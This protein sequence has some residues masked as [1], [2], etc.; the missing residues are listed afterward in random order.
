MS[1]KERLRQRVLE[2]LHARGRVQLKELR[3][4][5]EEEG[6]SRQLVDYH[7]TQLVREEKV[8]AYLG[9]DLSRSS[10]WLMPRHQVEKE[11]LAALDRLAEDPEAERLFLQYWCGKIDAAG[12]ECPEA[13][14]LV[15]RLRQAGERICFAIKLG[16]IGKTELAGIL[17]L[18]RDPSS[19]PTVHPGDP[20]AC[21]FLKAMENEIL[22]IQRKFRERGVRLT[23]LPVAIVHLD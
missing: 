5:L 12:A 19:I 10:I 18:F 7:I 13:Q 22:S 17:E 14:E 11:V 15:Q 2:I 3:R 1:K 21:A 23:L 6:Y 9:P 4:L 16:V 20:P 8:F